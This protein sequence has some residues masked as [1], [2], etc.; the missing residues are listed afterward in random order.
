MVPVEVPRVPPI[1]S[2]GLVPV[3][4]EEGVAIDGNRGPLR[5]PEVAGEES[6]GSVIGGFNWLA[7]LK[8][9][10]AKAAKTRGED[11]SEK[12]Q[13]NDNNITNF[14]LGNKETTTRSESPA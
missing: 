2:E 8:C 10:V 14:I 1:P 5:F 7:V 4:P 3:K 12:T 13:T 6:I 9:V 11:S